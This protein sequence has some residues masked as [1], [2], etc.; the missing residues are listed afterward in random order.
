MV[1]LHGMDKTKALP[2]AKGMGFNT[3]LD[4]KGNQEAIAKAL[5][6]VLAAQ[7]EVKDAASN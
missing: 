1:A 3:F 6:L 7:A 2:I 4:M 5:E